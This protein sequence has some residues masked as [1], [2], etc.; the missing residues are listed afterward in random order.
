M[1]EATLRLLGGVTRVIQTKWISNETCRERDMINELEYLENDVM[2]CVKTVLQPQL[3][4]WDYDTQ[5]R[6]CKDLV[7]ILNERVRQTEKGLLSFNI[8]SLRRKDVRS[9]FSGAK[10]IRCYITGV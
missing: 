6:D 1:L 5:V 10:A 4:V 8:G 2:H 9:V 3:E 7:T